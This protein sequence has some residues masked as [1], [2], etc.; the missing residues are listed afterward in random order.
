METLISTA[1]RQ[2]AIL[3]PFPFL[4]GNCQMTELIIQTGK[5]QGKRIDL[6]GKDCLIGRHESCK[7]RIA[8]GDV[9]KQHCRLKHIEG[10]VH[11]KDLGS[12]NGTFVNE[13]QITGETLLK[14]GDTLRVGPMTFLISEGKASP[15]ASEHVA[16]PSAKQPAAEA[17]PDKPADDDLIAAWLSE[18][19][20]M[21]KS[22]QDTTVVVP[23]TGQTAD[24]DESD[25]ELAAEEKHMQSIRDEARAI[26]SLYHKQQQ[27]K[28]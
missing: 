27:E 7:I 13:E 2:N 1:S 9:S 21:E 15:A 28:G 20:D 23:S 5:H 10:K 8:S 11:A 26:I 14:P 6:A 18:G 4:L 17:A 19:G 3:L 22:G 25:V 16:T 12:R 24:D